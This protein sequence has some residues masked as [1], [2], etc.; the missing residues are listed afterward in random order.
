[1]R[2]ILAATLA[3]L[4]SLAPQV[5]GADANDISV[6]QSIKINAPPDAVWE[7][8]GDFNGLARWLSFVEASE[9][10]AGTNNEVGCIRL[11]TRRNGTKVSE[12]LLEYDP[13]NMRFAYT[14]VDGAVMA[15]DY[16]PVVTVKPAQDGTCDVEW[17]A[18]FKRLDYWVDP[19]PEGQDDKSLVDRY[20]GLYKSGLEN[21]KRIVEG[22]Q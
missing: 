20:N 8:L 3:A 12:R 15:S 5:C 4:V 9:I 1:M 11:V 16:F 18:R 21:L 19:P 13:H 6:R 7:V 22:A 17:S 2:A 10:V 14:Y